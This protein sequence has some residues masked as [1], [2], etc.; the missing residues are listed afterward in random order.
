M[1][2][3][4]AIFNSV[5]INCHIFDSTISGLFNFIIDPYRICISDTFTL[6]PV[7]AISKLCFINGNRSVYDKVT[8]P[9]ID[10]D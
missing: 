9:T 10:K 2:N 1:R 5:V 6:S 7:F 4:Y 3:Q 8:G